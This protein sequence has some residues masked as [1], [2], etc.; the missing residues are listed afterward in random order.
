[1][2]TFIITR[3]WPRRRLNRLID[4]VVFCSLQPS[5]RILDRV[6]W[7]VSQPV[8]AYCVTVVPGCS[9]GRGPP[10]HANPLNN[11][12]FSRCIL[13]HHRTRCLDSPTWDGCRRA[14]LRLIYYNGPAT[15]HNAY[16]I[17]ITIKVTTLHSQYLYAFFDALKASS[18]R[19]LLSC[20]LDP[21]TN[22]I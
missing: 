12:S 14:P 1:M 11:C 20:S 7:F 21:P 19:R 6:S 13:V 15:L 9:S 10:S 17:T 4:H 18:R 2:Y 5:P 16:L 8:S 22:C 3:C